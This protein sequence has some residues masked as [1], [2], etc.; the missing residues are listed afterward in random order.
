MNISHFKNMLDSGHIHMAPAPYNS[1]LQNYRFIQ[2]LGESKFKVDLLENNKDKNYYACKIFNTKK[3]FAQLFYEKERDVGL[4]MTHKNTIKLF[5]C[6]ESTSYA[7]DGN[8]LSSSNLIINEFAPYGELFKYV[9]T[10]EFVEERLAH[11]IFKQVLDGL[12]FMHQNGYAHLDLKSENIFIGEDFI[13]K[14]GDYDMCCKITGTTVNHFVGTLGIKSPEMFEDGYFDPIKA[15]IFALGVLL[16]TLCFGHPPFIKAVSY[17]QY[18]KLIKLKS[19][20]AFWKKHQD[21]HN[22]RDISIQISEEFKL[23]T[24]WLL[25]YFDDSRPSI[26]QI[27]ESAWYKMPILNDEEYKSEFQRMLCKKPKI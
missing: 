27:K 26:D 17:D 23:L 6:I 24:V 2:R 10:Q 5:E 7:E 25:S 11:I 13:I 9:Q 18:Y 16:F 22:Q 19:Y 14:I 1:S 21:I 8:S 4:L 15:D 12:E 3:S 20:D